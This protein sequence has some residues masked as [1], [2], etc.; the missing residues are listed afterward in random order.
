MAVKVVCLPCLN[1]PA[2][3]LRFRQTIRKLRTKVKRIEWLPSQW[4]SPEALDSKRYPNPSLSTS[5]L[6]SQFKSESSFLH[7]L[8]L[9]LR[10][11]IYE[12]V[13]VD[14]PQDN[15]CSSECSNPVVQ[16][17]EQDSLSCLHRIPGRL[18]ST[19]SFGDQA[20]SINVPSQAISSI[21]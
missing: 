1:P 9:E 7:L 16:A 3:S 13:F 18:A 19:K 6:D 8:P 21:V 4:Q 2:S 17:L 12:F 15:D 11:R 10:L 14:T 5:F 20:V